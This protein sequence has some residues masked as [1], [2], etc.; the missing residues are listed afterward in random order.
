M[1]KL[2][3]KSHEWFDTKEN[4]IGISEYAAK[5]LGDVVYAELPEVG[6]KVSAGASFMTIESVKAVSD[7]YS[8]V[9]GEIVEVN[10]ELLS[11][12]E[13]INEKP[14]EAWLVKVEVTSVPQL[15]SEEAYKEII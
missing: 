9:S 4:T 1:S 6:D 2:F 8:P 15:L 7:V 11:A 12:P 10:E 14:Y 13:L 3:A 5:E